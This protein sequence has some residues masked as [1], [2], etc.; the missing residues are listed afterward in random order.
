MNFSNNNFKVKKNIFLIA[1]LI[2]NLAQGQIK[3]NVI[4]DGRIIKIP[5]V[6]HIVNKKANNKVTKLK[7]QEI[8]KQLNVNY[9]SSN[10][11]SN[12][13][14]ESKKL[15]GSPKIFFFLANHDVNSNDSKGIIRYKRNLFMSQKRR[16]NKSINKGKWLNIFIVK[17]GT[18]S[19]MLTKNNN[20]ISLKI[21][22]KIVDDGT[23]LTHEIGHWLGLWHVWGPGNCGYKKQIY[24][25]DEIPDT[26]KQ[27]TCTDVNRKLCDELKSNSYNFM[28]YSGCRAM[29]TK[30]QSQKMRNNIISYKRNLFNESS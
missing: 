23:S 1:V 28:D 8:I 15:L 25:S 6:L 13:D 3:K 12:V 7:A 17:K 20:S 26:P 4:D 27:K 14:L 2:F 16:A 19:D 22:Y 21:D 29:F 24:V 10:D 30:D 5:V 11:L 9:S 18:A